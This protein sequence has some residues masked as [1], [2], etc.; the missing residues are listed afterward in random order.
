MP[1]FFKEVAAVN[2]PAHQSTFWWGF[3]N[4]CSALFLA[5]TIPLI[6]TVADYRYWKKRLFLFFL[7]LGVAATALLYLIREGDWILALILFALAR[8]GWAGSMFLYDAFLVDVTT[9]SKMDRV[10]SLGY[11]AG[12]IGSVVPFIAVIFLILSSNSA[13][14]KSAIP[15][16]SAHLSFLIVAGWWSLFSIPFIRHVRHRRFQTAGRGDSRH[17]FSRLWSLLKEISAKKN[18]LLFLLAYFFYIDGVDTLITMSAAYGIDIGLDASMLV[19]VIL[20]IQVVAFPCTWIYGR[21]SEKVPP[22]KLIRFAI[23]LYAVITLIAFYLPVIKHQSMKKSVFWLIAVLTASSL[24]GIQALSRSC[25]ARMIPGDRSAEFFGLFNVFGRFAAIAG[26]L[27]MGLCSR[28][29]G[30]SRWGILSILVLFCAGFLIL[31]SQEPVSS[32]G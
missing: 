14:G 4:S 27:L 23:S 15:V 13:A 18:L 29:F 31:P 8:M 22:R 7:G 20:V 3:V 24:G 10:S 2:L 21:L 1:I 12:Y 17:A 25:Y 16:G 30:H 9:W 6:G 11:A 32:E 28:W 26:P 5:L 19:M